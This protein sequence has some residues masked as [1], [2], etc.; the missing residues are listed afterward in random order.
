MEKT[1]FYKKGFTLIELLIVVA[2]IGILSALLMTNFV[3]IRQRARDGQRKSDMRQIQSALEMYRADNAA[4]P[5]TGSLPTCG[6][7]FKNV[8]QTVTYMKTVPCDPLS[9]SGYTYTSGNSDTIYC[10]RAC[11]ENGSDPQVTDGS[12]A[13]P[14][15]GMANSSCSSGYVD[16]TVE[17]P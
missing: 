14:G 12:G 16:F 9:G 6:S 13:C 2:I 8:A 17:N 3:G 11:L 1:Q 4:Y 15:I 5:A 7:S 10:L